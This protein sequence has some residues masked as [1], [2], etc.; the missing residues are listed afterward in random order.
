MKLTMMLPEDC[1]PFANDAADVVRV[2]TGPLDMLIN[3]P[4]GDLA[5]EVS[6]SEENG[7]RHLTVRQGDHSSSHDAPVLEDH[8]DNKRLH[9]RQLKLSVYDCMKAL[10]GRTPPW[11]S[12]TG[13]RPTR[14]M[15]M[16]MER[17][18]GA[19]EAAREMTELFDV[20]DE[21]ALLLREIIDVQSSVSRPG[22][23]DVDIYIGIP[24]CTTRCAYCSFLSGEVGKGKQLEPY[25]EALEKEI[26]GVIRLTEEKGLRLRAFYMGGGTPTSLPA[27]LLRRV[28]KEAMPLIEQCGEVTVE[29]GRPDTI[30]E[31]KLRILK[32]CGVNRISINPQTMHDET[33]RTIG[34]RHTRQQCEDAYAMARKLD[35]HHINMD[36]IAGLPGENLEMFEQTLDWSRGL[37]PESLTVHT[38]SIKHS[39]LLHL[40]EA[41]LPD[42][43]MVARM[44]RRGAEEAHARGMRPYYL[45][46]QK[47]MA[48]NLENVGYAL[49]G[50]ACIYNIDMMEETG[51]IIALGAG[52]I[53]KRLFPPRGHIER[54]PNVSDVSHYMARVDEML[55]RKKDL[56][57]KAGPGESSAKE[58]TE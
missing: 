11:G 9:K 58:E 27:P 48:G 51:N 55:Q 14:L 13:I 39:S 32:D 45:Y 44:V 34:R 40:W 29:A 16:A 56:W 12:L 15:Y 33:L 17:G 10:T 2:F 31:E 57:E 5:L 53:S 23:K 43:D 28:M 21:K 25:T 7:V 38:L 1:V 36:L 35:F 41:K 49:P 30:D 54:A 52:G 6:E 47:Y 42:G 3:T 18:L 26:R 46:R 50:H 22:E 4:G 8:L 20:S 37:S 19:D 24:F